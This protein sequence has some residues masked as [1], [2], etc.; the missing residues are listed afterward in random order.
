MPLLPRDVGRKLHRNGHAQRRHG[1]YE[2]VE[3]RWR[4]LDR[5]VTQQ[6]Y[7]PMRSLIGKTGDGI[8][9]HHQSAL[10]D[11]QRMIERKLLLAALNGGGEDVLPFPR[12]GANEE[13]PWLAVVE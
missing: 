10:S 3:L 4:D 12:L 2:I 1:L 13:A 8:T 5:L 11:G 6:G 9:E 7:P